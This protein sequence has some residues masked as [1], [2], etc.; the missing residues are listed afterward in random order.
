MSDDWPEET[1]GIM[2]AAGCLARTGIRNIH[3]EDCGGTLGCDL[4]VNHEG[5]H[6]DAS[7]ETWWFPAGSAEPHDP[8]HECRPIHCGPGETDMASSI[9]P[10]AY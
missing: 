8:T 5:P 6:Y 2:A 4:D 3:A 1:E 9:P 7:D 10:E